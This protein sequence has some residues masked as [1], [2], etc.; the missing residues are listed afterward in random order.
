MSDLTEVENYDAGVYELE[1][2]DPVQGGPSGLSNTPLKNLANRTKYLKRHVDDLESGVTIPSTVAP[3]NSPGFSGNPTAPTPASG[4]NDTSLATS[5]FVQGTVNGVL[6][7]SVAGGANV[8]LTAAE[9]GNGIYVFTGALTANIAVIVPAS[10]KA[11]IVSNQTAGAFALTVK[12][13]AG[14]GVI[15][16]QGRNQELWCN[17]TN[18]LASLTDFTD[19]ALAGTPT[20]PT[21]A[22]FD[23][24]TKLATTAHVQRELGSFSGYSGHT[25]SATLTVSDIGK[26]T[27]VGTS[28]PS[29]AII[30]PLSSAAVLGKCI[31]IES[32]SSVPFTVQRQGSDTLSSNGQTITSITVQPGDQLIA[33]NAGSG[34]WLLCGTATLQFSYSFL[35]NLA[36]NGYQKLPGGLIIQWGRGSTGA[37]SN[38]YVI[39]TTFPIAFPNACLSLS[40]SHGVNV[41]NLDA[42]AYYRTDQELIQMGIPTNTGFKASMNVLNQTPD[43]RA[44][45]WIAI[46]Y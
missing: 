26:F 1:V 10:G 38:T 3:L 5:A 31:Y 4:D 13:A 25:A 37:D 24:S 11:M 46:G 34:Q 36:S 39:D 20:A 21:P 19:T 15:V 23:N 27:N 28:L 22:Q 2:A 44:Y 16:A 9:A 8:T 7:K 45:R 17:G 40:V 18:V 33:V 29:Q 14:T 6:S 30:L 43:A 12:T 32:S 41:F 42:V 35:S